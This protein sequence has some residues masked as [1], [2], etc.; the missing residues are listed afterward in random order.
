MKSAKQL[1]PYAFKGH[2]I[3]VQHKTPPIC[4]KLPP[5]LDQL[6]RPMPNRS[7][8]IREAILEKLQREGLYEKK[9]GPQA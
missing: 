9:T 1:E 7:E 6:V 2:G 4:A 3:G 8:F 5:E